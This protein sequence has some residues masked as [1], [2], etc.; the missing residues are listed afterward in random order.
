M[1]IQPTNAGIDFQ[2]RVSALMMILMEFEIDIGTIMSIDIMDKIQKLNFESIDKIDDLVVTTSTNRKI[3]MQMKRNIAFSTEENSEFYSVCAQFV[4]Q[5]VEGKPED[6][7]YV[8]VTRTQASNNI[9]VKL[10]RILDGI[11][12]ANSINIESNLNKNEIDLLKKIER[13]IQVEYE[14]VTENVMSDDSLKNLLSKIYIEVFDVESG[15][16]FEK[17]IKLILQSRLYG[18]IE[19]FW[20][21]VISK[22]VQY[23]ANRNCLDKKA[24]HKQIER[25]LVVHEDVEKLVNFEWEDDTEISIQKDYV[26]AL[27]N[28]KVNIKMGL[29]NPYENVILLMELYRFSDE[30]KKEHLQYVAPNIMNFGNDFS[31]EIL[32][33]CSSSSRMEKYIADGEL[34]RYANDGY[35]MIYVPARGEAA[36]EKVEILYGD[37]IKKSIEEKREGIC[38]NCGKAIFDREAYIIE[39]DNVECSGQA[40]LIHKECIRPVDR[41]L[42]IVKIPCANEYDYLKN[43]NINLWIKL[44]LKGKQIW[45][46]I[47]NLQQNIS[48]LVIDTD[49]V[50]TDGKYCVR[51]ILSDGNVRYATYRGKIH[52]MSRVEAELFAN[53]LTEEYQEA[54]MQGNPVCYSN[55]TYVY[56]SYEQLLVQMEGKEELLECVCAEVAIYNDTIARMYNESETYYAPIIYLSIEGE[57]VVINGA[58][59]L[60]TNPMKL[61]YFLRNWR[62]AG[63]VIEDYEVNIIKEDSDFILK[64]LSLISNDVR[65]VVDMI[66][67]KGGQ[68]VK[69]CV[70][71]TMKEAEKYQG[72]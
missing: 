27:G 6:L 67:A 2:Q 12:L 36:K 38:V 5:Y 35:K 46:S 60:I 50:F 4:K 21:M 28:P 33:R 14:K 31:F 18:D 41:V 51:T 40:G 47:N 17:T 1:A 42:G 10:K 54:S 52:R 43:F 48:P 70:I 15:E 26:I 8:L 57:P 61:N 19:Q 30:K 53:R 55:E 32:F 58:F 49:E 16:S 25:H 37:S 66:I 62:Q 34:E 7:A 68:L 20:G 72:K 22:A 23:A 63:I 39:I 13:V 24:F 69:G 44:I 9:T 29:E 11:R 3:Y 64:I 59:P 45:G 56:G 65:P 71:Y